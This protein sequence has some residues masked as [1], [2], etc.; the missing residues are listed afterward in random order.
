MNELLFH[1]EQDDGWLV[2]TCHDPEM[3]TQA[4]SLDDLLPMIRDLV[5]CRFDAGDRNSQRPIRLHFVQDPVLVASELSCRA[6]CPESRFV[7]P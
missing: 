5:N 4:Q 3:A 7:G 2:A 6:T 1:V